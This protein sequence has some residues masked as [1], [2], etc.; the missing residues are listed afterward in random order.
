MTTE[1]QQ[2]QQSNSH[3]YQAVSPISRLLPWIPP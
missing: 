2:Q 3:H 1:Q